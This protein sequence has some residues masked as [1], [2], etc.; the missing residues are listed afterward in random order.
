MKFFDF[1]DEN[2]DK[3]I[4]V[5]FDMDGVFA[6]FDLGNFD[7]DTI[8]PIKSIIEIMK[9]LIERGINVKIVSICRT[10]NIVDQKYVW[11][12]RNVPFFD[13]NN[14][15][16]IS[17]EKEENVGFESNELKSNFLKEHIDEN[18]VNIEVDDDI[19]VI[20]KIQKDNPKVKV[21]HISSLIK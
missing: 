21:Y 2:I 3:G 13:K 5:Y 14:I 4:D 11:I 8:R 19:V 7:Y 17:K 6:E 18:R 10:N 12:D 16:F 9:E 20:R 15:F 1:I